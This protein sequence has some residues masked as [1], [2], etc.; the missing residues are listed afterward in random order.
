MNKLGRILLFSCCAIAFLWLFYD[1]KK[2]NRKGDS[3]FNARMYGS[4]FLF[5]LSLFAI[6]MTLMTEDRGDLS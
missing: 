5:F 2:Q 1:R 3:L 4:L 6:V